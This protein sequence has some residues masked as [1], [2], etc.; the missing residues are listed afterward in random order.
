M[1][2]RYI[3][4][5]I[6]ITTAASAQEMLRGIFPAKDGIVTYSGVIQADSLMTKERLYVNGE[7]WFV[8]EYKSAPD[9]IQYKNEGDGEIIGKGFFHAYWQINRLAGQDVNVHHTVKFNFKDGRFKYTVT[10]FILKYYTAPSQYTKG[11]NHEFP[12]EGWL[13]TPNQYK[14]IDLFYQQIHASV[15][16]MIKSMQAI[17]QS[18]QTE[19]KW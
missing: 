9:V 12:I 15:I 16:K 2:Y 10:D 1:F 3:L 14:N 11:G 17:S 19:E 6:F 7:K 18:E 13:A 5:L 8:S 4:F